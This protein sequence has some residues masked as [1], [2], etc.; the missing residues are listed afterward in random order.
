MSDEYEEEI[1]SDGGRT[2]Y[3][4]TPELIQKG[5]ELRAAIDTETVRAL[6][7]INGGM[8]AGLVTMLPT[9]IRDSA[10]GTLGYWMIAA[11]GFAALGLV[12][13]T[14][15]NRLRRKCSVEH[16]KGHNAD[17]SYSSW[18]LRKCQSAPG[19][20]RVCTQSVISMWTSL[21]LFCLGA[22]AIGTGFISAHANAAPTAAACWDLQRLGDRIY[23]FNRCTGL[24]EAYAG[25]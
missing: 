18:I 2:V 3:P 19:E 1:V 12:A 17:V 5:V 10:Y 25:K 13:A 16:T 20:P 4:V 8:A 14:I 9:I 15:H 7:L 11:I 21:I 24:A 23:K 6:Q 22:I